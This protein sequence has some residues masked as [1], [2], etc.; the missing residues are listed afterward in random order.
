MMNS[1][2]GMGM[3]AQ[4]RQPMQ[5]G[6]PGSQMRLP[7]QHPI[8]GGGLPSDMQMQM[9]RPGGMPG[10]PGFAP[11][12]ARAASQNPPMPN[13]PQ[14]P[15]LPP[16]HPPGMQQ[17]SFPAGMAMGGQQ[18]HGQP[19]QQLGSSPHPVPQVPPAGMSNNM[20]G[21]SGILG[22]GSQPRMPPDRERMYN[23]QNPQMQSNMQPRMTPGNVPMGFGSASN[24]PN[25]QVGA[26]QQMTEMQ[27]P[28]GGG[29]LAG[30]QRSASRQGPGTFVTP[31][32]MLNTMNGEAF[33]TQFMHP[34]N[35][36]GAAPP[37]P[38][39]QQRMPYPMPPQQQPIPQQ[40]P[41]QQQQPSHSL[42]PPMGVH[43]SPRQPDMAHQMMQRPGSQPPVASAPSPQRTGRTNTPRVLPS[44]LP[45]AGGMNV[46]RTPSLASAQPQGPPAP[47]PKPPT[48]AS[49]N[50]STAGAQQV[51]ITSRPQQP[52]PT[53]TSQAPQPPSG[54]G[55]T[56]PEV[57]PSVPHSLQPPQ[58]QPQSLMP[59]RAPAG[60]V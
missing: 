19:P 21:A 23:F 15:S 31:A 36:A 10:G 35:P 57:G 8:Q 3:P 42:Q 54:A 16:S 40:Q 22:A 27:Q 28:L 38:P 11:H 29:N 14:P 5:Q 60:S 58:P 33:P 45:Q 26:N 1:M 53:I 12:I 51:P 4:M 37:R 24:T 34:Q 56:P 9:N 43:R 25:P 13:I 32:E 18:M 50:P 6:P 17:P 39:S 55:P 41:T 44:Q 7:Q 59:Q 49:A 52:P 48:P 20:A 47:P 30:Q 46:N 2:P